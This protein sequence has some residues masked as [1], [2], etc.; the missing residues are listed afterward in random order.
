MHH[1]VFCFKL[2]EEKIE[3]KKTSI[4]YIGH[5]L[6]SEGVKADPSKIEAIL[7]MDRPGDVAGVRRI[8]GTVNYL[9]KF[10]PRLSEVSEPL[11]QL[12]KK[13]SKFSWNRTGTM[14]IKKRFNQL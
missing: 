5:I 1:R 2:N 10:L 9:A 7:K 4:P 13:D 12:T 11:R 6:T 3:L 14:R 8:M